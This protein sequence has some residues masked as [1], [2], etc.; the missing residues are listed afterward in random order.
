[1]QA[2]SHLGDIIVSLHPLLLLLLLLLLLPNLEDKTCEGVLCGYSLNSTAY[3]IY[4]NKTVRVTESRN[5]TFIETPE[6][7]LDDST[8]GYTTGNAVC[9]H[10]DRS[11]GEKT[12]DICITYSEEID[13][14]LKKVSKLTS[15]NLDHSTSAGEEEPAAEGAG[16]D[17]TLETIRTGAWPTDHEL[18]GAIWLGTR[19][20]CAVT[21]VSRKGIFLH[22]QRELRNLRLL[23]SPMVSDAEVA[24][25]KESPMEYAL[26]RE[27]EHRSG[28]AGWKY[29]LTTP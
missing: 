19:A 29:T 6:L 14:L 9:T 26:V 17:E 10:E 5:V 27:T 1:M 7:T 24:H 12:Q 16:S 13:S 15:R 11:L 4:I 22:Q 18:G 28:G 23:T 21:P 8:G 25:E 2:W 20:H 3:H